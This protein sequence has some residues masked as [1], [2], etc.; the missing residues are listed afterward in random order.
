MADETQI[1]WLDQEWFN[2]VGWT[3]SS[4]QTVPCGPSNHRCTQCICVVCY[5]LLPVNQDVA[6]A[7]ASMYT[8][9]GIP[10][11]I[12]ALYSSYLYFYFVYCITGT[13]D[14]ESWEGCRGRKLCIHLFLGLLYCA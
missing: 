6:I 1:W 3:G 12:F 9:C 14:G 7:S 8:T 2:L 11:Y 5:W 13:A 10:R 4:A